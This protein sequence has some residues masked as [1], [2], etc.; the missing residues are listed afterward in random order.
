MASGLGD[1]GE[2]VEMEHGSDDSDEVMYDGDDG[3]EAK[4]QV[5]PAMEYGE[6]GGG[7]R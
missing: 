7:W 2:R 5:R 3:D 6:R 1:D 4:L